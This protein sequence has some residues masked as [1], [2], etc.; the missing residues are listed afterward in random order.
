MHAGENDRLDER[1]AALLSTAGR[2]AAE[3]DAACLN[4]LREESKSVYLAAAEPRPS[5]WGRHRI[6]QENTWRWLVPVA[7][8]A[9]VL[10]AV[11][12]WPRDL[13]PGAGGGAGRVYAMTDVPGL[14]Y[15]AETL[16]LQGV[17][18]VVAGPHADEKS[19]EMPF[20]WWLDLHN[21][22]MCV[23]M[24][25]PEATGED[26]KPLLQ[27]T[28]SDGEF[29][30]EVNRSYPVHGDPA[31][32][33]RY[34]RLTPFTSRLRARQQA[35]YFT[36]MFGN[37][38][39]FA[40][41]IKTGEG[42]IDGLPY[43]VWDGQITRADGKGLRIETWLSPTTGRLGRVRAWNIDAA[44]A[45]GPVPFIDFLRVEYDT[46]APPG[47][48][49]TDPPEGV[50]LE[51]TKETAPWAELGHGPPEV[52]AYALIA[53]IG[54]TLGDG[55]VLVAW[56][57]PDNTVETQATLFEGL[58]TGGTLPD[59]PAVIT[60]LRPL[61]PEEDLTYVGRHLT[62]TRKQGRFY[63]WSLFVPD[64]EP[65]PRLTFIYYALVV[66]YHADLDQFE[67]RSRSVEDLVVR[68]EDEFQT[69]VVSAIRELSDE[70][71]AFPTVSY[72]TVLELSRRLQL[73]LASPE[74]AAEK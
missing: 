52:E 39:H 7:A 15:R 67:S 23:L 36:R 11:G 47:T 21:G 46:P 71:A 40:G 68:N 63:E 29:L 44:R 62:H 43:D 70:D 74:P 38:D 25:N 34:T 33:V 12:V 1:M 5:R 8:A 13:R 55:S 73:E 35:S 28:V 14:I 56:S 27:K 37:V 60:G 6:L 10:V 31:R 59:L 53:H 49:S 32:Y 30:M 17:A 58:E 61:S 4:R 48:F 2:H 18:N 3:S 22:K 42:Q 54:F 45:Q 51:N 69:W 64:R 16:H 57:C 26:G 65:P 66:D 20:E 72:D 9:G 41:F 19:R 50:A 24:E